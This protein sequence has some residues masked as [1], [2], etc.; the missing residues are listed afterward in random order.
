MGTPWQLSAC[1]F[2][3]DL[4]GQLKGSTRTPT[5]QPCPA[6]YQPS[7]T[8]LTQLLSCP[9]LTGSGGCDRVPSSRFLRSA[10]AALP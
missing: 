10:L 7:A 8:S 2:R 3:D 4:A 9:S 5:A 1:G 6:L